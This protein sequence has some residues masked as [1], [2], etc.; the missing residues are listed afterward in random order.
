GRGSPIT[1]AFDFSP[2]SLHIAISCEEQQLHFLDL[3]NQRQL[4]ALNVGGP[5]HDVLISPT[6]TMLAIAISNRVELWRWPES[7][8]IQSLI[9][10]GPVT[11]F[12]WHPD[13]RRL[14]SA[15][16][17]TLDVLLWDART[18]EQRAL[19]GHAE[20]VPHLAFDHQAELLVSFSWDGST[21][22]WQ[23]SDGELLFIS[24]AGFGLEFD[25]TDTR[26]AYSR[27]QQ[28]FGLWNISRSSVYREL[29][30]PLGAT[31][32]IIGFDFSPDGR[33]VAMLN[34]E[35]LH[36]FDVA[37]MA[38]RSFLKVSNPLSVWFTGRDRLV[39][40]SRGAI[41]H[42][43]TSPSQD[44]PWQVEKALELPAHTTLDFGTMTRGSPAL[45]AVPTSDSVFWFDLNDPANLHQLNGR[46]VMGPLTGAAISPN[47][48]WIATTY[49]K[50][51]GTAVWDV[52]SQQK[53]HDLGRTGGF[54]AFSPDNRWLLVGSAHK[55]TVW[56]TATWQQS[57]EFARQTT[58]EL[59]GAG[60]FSPDGKLLAICPE[61]NQIRLISLP[62][63]QI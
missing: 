9:H 18:G 21:R 15:A 2:D 49:W 20:L 26:L 58:G 13:G 7:A 48:N 54:V 37:T 5:A 35:G 43:R 27:E 30:L 31:P 41:T 8:R 34:S 32:Y 38:E 44:I 24:R 62:Q 45:A 23:A 28:G 17:G 59:T 14:A 16:R 51:G 12:A 61:V 10:P 42:W 40:V 56:D 11:A 36:L 46:G 60:A 55:Y 25:Q 52:H 63:G 47:T 6:G 33:S 29:T 19:K 3:Q 1:A 4:S 50:G 22:F 53:V 57:F 39:C